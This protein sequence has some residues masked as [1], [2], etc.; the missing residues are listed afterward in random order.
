MQEFKYD[1]DLILEHDLDF[2]FKVNVV[3]PSIQKGLHTDNL[4]PFPNFFL[5]IL[6]FSIFLCIIYFFVNYF[7]LLVNY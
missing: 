4:P 2:R 6:L 1:S 5:F 7:N 3:I